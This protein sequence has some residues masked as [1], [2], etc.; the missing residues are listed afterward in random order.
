MEDYDLACRDHDVKVIGDDC[1]FGGGSGSRFFVCKN[2]NC[3]A[4][5]CP[6]G[7]MPPAPVLCSPTSPK[8]LQFVI[9]SVSASAD[10]KGIFHQLSLIC[11]SDD[12]KGQ[13]GER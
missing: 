12:S 5:S 6:E 7:N 11:R 10:G 13:V 9:V 4:P 8:S 2:L 3:A 1:M